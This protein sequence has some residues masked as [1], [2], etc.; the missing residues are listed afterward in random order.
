MSA[1]TDT[2]PRSGSGKPSGYW[3][4][5]TRP[6]DLLKE[7]TIALVV[8]SLLT[9]MLAALFS[10]PDDRG[11]TLQSWAKNAPDD[12]YATVV[13]E[14]AG[15]SGS[16]G[17]GAPYNSNSDGQGIG[18]LALQKWGGVTI[19][20]DPANQFVIDP[21]STQPDDATK[22]LVAKWK[23]ASADQQTAWATA[24]DDALTKAE[25]DATKVEAGD[26]GPV[27]DLAKAEIAM[28]DAGALDSAM[29]GG[30][31]F[32]QTNYTRA[33]LFLGDGAFLEDTAGTQHLQGGQWGMMNSVGNYPGQA[34]LWLASFWYQ[35]P[36]FNDENTTI[37]ANADAIVFG[38]IIAVLSLLLML[39]PFIP[40]LRDIPRL[41]PLHRLIWRNWYAKHGT[42]G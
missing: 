16:A 17:Y 21:L 3:T 19:K 40:G 9:V 36:P 10:S 22:A 39:V 42:G 31:G 2:K 12:M 15:T 6:Y 30:G 13:A 35:I 7:G 41:I 5:P 14:L 26:Y 1:S 8:V 11:L 34:W 32:Y 33:M 20:V 27:P 29:V 25:G 23:G 4:G 38:A 37:G 24:Y 28:A 18:P